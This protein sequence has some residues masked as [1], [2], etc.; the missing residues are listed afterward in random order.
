MASLIFQCYT[1]ELDRKESHK[2]KVKVLSDREKNEL[3]YTCYFKFPQHSK[4]IACKVGTNTNIK[5]SHRILK[6]RNNANRIKINTRPW[7]TKDKEECNGLR[8]A[9][10]CNEK[11]SIYSFRTE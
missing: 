8:A 1:Y 4:E 3:L 11:T 2:K 9:S 10:S 5:D 6:T 7:I